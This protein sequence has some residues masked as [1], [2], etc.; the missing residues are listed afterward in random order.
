MR[1]LIFSLFFTAILTFFIG[2][3]SDKTNTYNHES[4]TK[5]LKDWKAERLQKLKSEDGWLNIVGLYWINEGVNKIGSHP[6]NN[7]I[8]PANAPEFIGAI[9]KVKNQIQI[10]IN[11]SIKVIN[12]D[13]LVKELYVKTDK[14]GLPSKFQWKNYLWYIIERN[15]KFALRLKDLESP[16]TNKIKAIPYYPVDTAFR[17][18]ASFDRFDSVMHIPISDVTGAV[19]E[20]ECFGKLRFKINGKEHNLYPAGDGRTEDF[21]VMF[22]DA[23]SAIETYGGG[24]YLYIKKPDENNQTIIDFNKSTNPPCAFTQFA[25]C[26]LPPALN[27]LNINVTA[28]EKAIK[29]MK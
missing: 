9:I 26:P 21:F 4:Y 1:K 3:N 20:M 8:F 19:S 10:S 6:D 14:D 23:T 29:H 16:Q 15:E 11:D 12:N 25:T 2:C 28:G 22:A 7:I 17:V 13:S 5:E 27:I 24:R 18:K